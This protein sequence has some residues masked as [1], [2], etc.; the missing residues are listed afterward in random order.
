MTYLVFCFFELRN[1]SREDYM[2]VYADLA[3]LGLRKTV[4]ADDGR[5]VAMPATAVMGMFDGKNVND[6][7][8]DLASQVEDVF[9]TR[10]YNG[11]FFVVVSA[12]WACGG[13]AT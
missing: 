11:E 2:Y 13:G 4:K 12:D 9:K 7:R 6:V 8:S 1:A 10:G 5:S 3:R